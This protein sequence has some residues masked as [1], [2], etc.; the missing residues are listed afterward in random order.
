MHPTNLDFPFVYRHLKH[1]RWVDGLKQKTD[2]VSIIIKKSI[3]FVPN[4]TIT[5]KYNEKSNNR[6]D[7]A[8]G[9]DGSGSREET[10]V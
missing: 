9:D 10:V 3:I 1:I 2:N 4:S 8:D 7:A 5:K 6:I